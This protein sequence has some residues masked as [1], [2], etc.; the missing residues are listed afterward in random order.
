LQQGGVSLFLIDQHGEGAGREES[1]DGPFEHSYTEE[2]I[3]HEKKERG[4]KK[5]EIK[6][7]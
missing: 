7:D 4:G 1:G 3:K 5:K 6:L 2:E